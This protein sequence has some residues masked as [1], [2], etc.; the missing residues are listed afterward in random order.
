ME[1]WD[2]GIA[3]PAWDHLTWDSPAM[4][5]KECPYCWMKFNCPLC[6][7]S[8]RLDWLDKVIDNILEEQAA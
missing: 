6:I 5:W 4:E 1:T 3:K 7:E 2:E 8:E